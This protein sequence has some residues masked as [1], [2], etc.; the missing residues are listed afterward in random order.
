MVENKN[1]LKKLALKDWY[2]IN[3]RMG[4]QKRRSLTLYFKK[5]VKKFNLLTSK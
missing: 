2:F 3:K 5:F 4:S 1:R